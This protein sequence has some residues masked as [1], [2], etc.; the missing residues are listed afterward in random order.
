MKFAGVLMVGGSYLVTPFTGVW[1]EIFHHLVVA[2]RRTVTPFTGV[3][4]EIEMG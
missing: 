2:V 3:W 4:I 1:I